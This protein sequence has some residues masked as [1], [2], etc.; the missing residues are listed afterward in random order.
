[1]ASLDPPPLALTSFVADSILH[2]RI[3]TTQPCVSLSSS[4]WPAFTCLHVLPSC[5]LP[6]VRAAAA[7]A[8]DDDDNDNGVS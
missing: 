1:M 8:A 3:H 4:P 5:L 7:A 2:H 6:E